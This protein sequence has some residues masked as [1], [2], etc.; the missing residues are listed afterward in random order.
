[1]SLHHRSIKPRQR[2]GW[3]DN[4][5]A[6]VSILALILGAFAMSTGCSEDADADPGPGD[7]GM[8]GS[9]GAFSGSSGGSGGGASGVSSTGGAS[10]GGSSGDGGGASDGGGAGDGGGGSSTGGASGDGGAGCE[11]GDYYVAT[12][13]D[14]SNPGTIDRP[15]ATLQKA[16]DEAGPGDLVY[17]RGG[18]Y[19]IRKR[20][21][22][23]AGVHFHKSGTSD[24]NRIRYFA[25]PGEVPAFDFA[26]LEIRS[27]PNYTTGVVVDGA[28]LHL[29]GFEVRNMPMNTR[30]NNAVGVSGDAHDDIFELM[31]IHHNNGSGMFISNTTG[32]HQIINCDSHDN[33]DPHSHQGDG[34]N[35]DGFGVH[36]QKTGKPTVFRGCRAWWNSDDGWDFIS[37]E[38]P[39][40][41]E[42]SWAYGNGYS[43]SGRSRP[44]SGNGNGFKIGSS[45][46]GI[47][48]V[49]RG[50][51][52]WGNRASGFYANH[53][54]GGN[55]WFNNTSY[56]NGTQFNM[57][58]S[59]WDSEGNRTDGVVL[60]GDKVHRMRNN[61]S[62]PL[63][64]TNMQGVDERFNSWNLRLTPANS[65]FVSVDDTGTLGPRQPDGSLPDLDFLKLRDGSRMIDKGTDVGLPYSGSAPD[66]GAYER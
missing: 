44:R 6:R 3:L 49:V 57:L 52:A 32:G 58:A 41:V 27:D 30:S 13:G 8:G 18:T 19:E 31:N 11:G 4:E 15:F 5:H 46:T 55:D 33:Y 45:K 9:S 56:D 59:S 50:S 53:S 20:A 28:W 54:A 21:T 2:R 24:T 66:L 34:Q 25:C 36:Y 16:I 12:D 48:H 22:G 40:I 61:I 39:V 7:S 23:S 65:D 63:D 1:M 37:Q 10:S 29:K 38:V 64:N 43:D 42:N 17:V 51:L 14:D 47:R 62:F 26:K 60:T 35:A